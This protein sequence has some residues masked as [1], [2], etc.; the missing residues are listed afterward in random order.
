MS[1]RPVQLRRAPRWPAP[2]PPRRPAPGPAPFLAEP[3]PA[4]ARRATST[5][6]TCATSSPPGPG[7]LRAPARRGAPPRGR[8]GVGDAI[9]VDL[10][11]AGAV[12]DRRPAAA[13]RCS[14]V[15]DPSP[16][17][18]A[19]WLSGTAA[20]RAASG[21][22]AL[23]GARPGAGARRPPPSPADRPR[24]RSL[25]VDV[26][27]G[28]G[29]R[30]TGTVA[31]VFGARLVSLGYSR[32]R[33][34]SSGCRPGSTCWRSAPPTP[35]ST[36]PPTR[37]GRRP[38]PAV[39]QRAARP[40]STTA[41]DVAPRPGRAPRPRAAASR[42]RCR[43]RPATPGRRRVQAEGARHR[44]GAPS[45]AGRSQPLPG[46]GR[47]TA[48]P[49]PCLGPARRRSP[50]PGPAA[51]R[52][53]DLG[54][55]HRLGALAA[56]SGSRSSPCASGACDGRAPSPSTSPAPLP[57]RHHHRARGERRH[58]QDL[59]H[60][61]AGHPLR[62]RGHAPA[63]T[64]CCSSRSAGPRARS[65]ASGCAPRWS[66]RPSALDDPA[67]ADG[68]ATPCCAR[69]DRRGGRRAS[70]ARRARL[71]D[72]LASF[73]AATIATTHQFCQLVLRSL[74]RRR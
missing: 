38:G 70:P 49:R 40:R 50:P 20:A 23:A 29:R 34:A 33:R 10:D 73:D 15:V 24:R 57:D 11:A 3:A 18:T 72:A 45:D 55:P 8:D 74:G 19:E 36:S 56:G 37:V 62:R 32:L 16:S 35:T 25:D 30:L 21:G 31:G 27:L 69:S 41:P 26:D 71:R 52:R 58:R 9:P 22:A 46:R 13:P 66:R 67:R 17:S 68:L 2:G 64:R 1:R 6:P 47:P 51:R 43:S 63:S 14:R 65:C 54:Q 59:D 44:C 7:F 60:R 4:G 12:G 5:S 28:D 39:A 53:D 42:S 48:R 61:R